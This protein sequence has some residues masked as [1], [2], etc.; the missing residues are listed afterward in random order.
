MLPPGPG[1]C[2]GAERAPSVSPLAGSFNG[3][4][5]SLPAHEL[6]AAA[7]REVLRRAGLAPEEVSEV[8]LGQVL[9]AGTGRALPLRGRI[10]SGLSH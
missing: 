10:P 2:P 1:G 9:T 7:I 4:L 6:G 5:S 8:I 3:G